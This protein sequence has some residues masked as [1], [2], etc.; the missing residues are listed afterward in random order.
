M[1]YYQ[2]NARTLEPVD[3]IA[4]FTNSCLYDF[5]NYM[6]SLFYPNGEYDHVLKSNDVRHMK[7]FQLLLKQ[8]K[9]LKDYV[10]S[11]LLQLNNQYDD[12]YYYQGLAQLVYH[13]GL[14]S[15][16]GNANEFQENSD[17]LIIPLNPTSVMKDYVRYNE[18]RILT[19]SVD[20]GY[21]D[22]KN[23]ESFFEDNGDLKVKKQK[24]RII[25]KFLS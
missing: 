13:G 6:L 5:H 8:S 14:V 21:S 15:I 18:F 1:I 12:Y 23:I 7:K 24:Q 10:D 9:F 16:V 25:R 20:L 17:I 3:Q 11:S 2:K 4:K 19:P 22:G